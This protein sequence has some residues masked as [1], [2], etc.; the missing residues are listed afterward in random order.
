LQAVFRAFLDGA[1]ADP[2]ALDRL[3]V[4]GRLAR[5]NVETSVDRLSAEPYVDAAQLRVLNAALASSHRFIHAA[6]A[7]EAGLVSGPLQSSSNDALRTFSHDVELMLYLLA[8]RL[9]GS[10]VTPGSLPNLREDHNRLTGSD[11]LL[12]IETDRMTNSLNTLA[13]QVFKWLAISMGQ[14]S[15]LP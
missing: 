13:E 14:V 11:P 5:S 6:M 9:R 15:N 3:R 10:P 7:L 8:A 12:V 4:N 1:G 2:H